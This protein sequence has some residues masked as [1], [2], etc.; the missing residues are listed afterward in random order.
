MR[1]ISL[2]SMA[3]LALFG[4]CGTSAVSTKATAVTTSQT[5]LC[6]DLQGLQTSLNQLSTVNGQSTVGQYQ[7]ARDNVSSH[8]QKVK[9]SAQGVASSKT[10]LLNTAY[11]NLEHA[12]NQLPQNE[13]ISQA[14]PTL[15]P[16]LADLKSAYS[17]TY[18]TLNCQNFVTP[19]PTQAGSTPT[20]APT[21]STETPTQMPT[22]PTETPTQVPSVPTP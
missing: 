8:F 10:D 15:Q 7:G 12:I 11:N 5:Q 14:L 13:T 6:T 3:M 2:A 4:G 21:T 18:S 22:T 17:Q 9:Q 1:W 16:Q 19:L 20:Q